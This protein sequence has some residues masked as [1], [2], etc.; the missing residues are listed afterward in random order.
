MLS[1]VESIHE[2][3]QEYAEICDENS[4]RGFYICPVAMDDHAM[5]CALLTETLANPSQISKWGDIRSRARGALSALHIHP[6]PKIASDIHHVLAEDLPNAAALV[7]A[8]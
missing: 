7:Q 4:F 3:E 2:R 1:R 6:G 8:A 5:N